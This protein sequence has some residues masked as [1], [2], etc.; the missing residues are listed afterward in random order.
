MGNAECLL[1]NY[2]NM[3]V[4]GNKLNGNLLKCV[5]A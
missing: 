4:D 3:S 1:R 5:V 2:E